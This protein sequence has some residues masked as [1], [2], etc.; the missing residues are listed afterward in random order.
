MLLGAWTNSSDS[1]AGLGVVDVAVVVG[2]GDTAVVV[3]AVVV[4]VVCGADVSGAV[5]DTGVASSAGQPY[6]D[7]SAVARSP[8]A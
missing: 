4:V 3:V 7:A 8:P 1:G 2:V 5:V 6:R